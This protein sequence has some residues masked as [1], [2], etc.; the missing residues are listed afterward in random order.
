MLGRAVG[1]ELGAAGIDY[2]GTGHELDIADDER[3]LQFGVAG[4]FSHIIN[5]AAFTDVDGAESQEKLAFAVNAHGPRNVGKVASRLG[6]LAVHV[7]TDYA[8]DGE[9][10][11]PYGE[12]TRTNPIGEY[13]RSK[14][15]GEEAFLEEDPGGL[16]VRTSWLFGVG[17]KNFVTTMIR[18]MTERS[19]VAVVADQVGR[20]TYTKDLA[21]AIVSLA[22]LGARGRPA[23]PGRYHFAN[24]GM[25]SWHEFAVAI[26]ER[27]KARPEL[28]IVCNNVRAIA[29]SEYPTRARRPKYSVLEIAKISQ[30]LG[31]T[32]RLWTEALDDYLSVLVDELKSKASITTHRLKLSR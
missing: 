8:F 28:H 22:G 12:D 1:A 15:A 7:S 30:A 11:T 6:A 17:G 20:P 16:I 24:S 19:E 13:G 9:A 23:I 25:A 29:T 21:S 18:L 4:G 2:V 26:F 31:A 27:V 14:V 10:S 3:V 32:P 5:C